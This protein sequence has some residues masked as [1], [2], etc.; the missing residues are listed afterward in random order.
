MGETAATLG[1]TLR[2]LRELKGKSLKAVAEPAEIS[3][4]Y[5][6]KLEKDQV[7]SPSP[8]VLHRLSEE[9]ETSYIGLMRLAGYVVPDSSPAPA[10][11]MAVAL[12]SQ[13]LTEDEA[14]AVATFLKTY[15]GM[16]KNE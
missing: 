5:L 10:G 1:E 6:L 14:R 13:D 15:R 16:S 3:T 11:A 9:L 2:S 4:A 8:R 12:S 7:T